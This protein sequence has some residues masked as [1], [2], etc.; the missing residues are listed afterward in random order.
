[1]PLA[2]T[3]IGLGIMA[4]LGLLLVRSATPPA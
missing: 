4:G 2:L 1:V 3:L